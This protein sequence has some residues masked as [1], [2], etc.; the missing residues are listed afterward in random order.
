MT[1]GHVF[2]IQ[3]CHGAALFVRYNQFQVSSCGAAV[4]PSSIIS[5]VERLELV[6][7]A[8]YHIRLNQTQF[9]GEW[10]FTTRLV[11]SEL[12]SREGMLASSRSLACY[13][14]VFS[15]KKVAQYIFEM[16]TDMITAERRREIFHSVLDETDP[17]VR[18]SGRQAFV[19]SKPKQ[20]AKPQMTSILG[21]D[22]HNDMIQA[23]LCCCCVSSN[24]T[25]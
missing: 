24:P 6:S 11:V 8:G 1:G 3:L 25:I 17:T 5:T 15:I 7:S 19:Q 16:P 20:S 10:G 23:L 13:I 12:Q 18:L 4:V 21:S 14:W 22:A 9:S 2:E